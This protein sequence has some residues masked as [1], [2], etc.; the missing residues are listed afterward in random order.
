MK[1]RLLVLAI[2]VVVALILA[3]AFLVEDTQAPDEVEPGA[4]LPGLR[5][6]LDLAGS[7]ADLRSTQSGGP[8]SWCEHFSA[9]T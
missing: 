5:Y 3:F 7:T 6:A 2:A 9:L 8:L 1:E 4:A